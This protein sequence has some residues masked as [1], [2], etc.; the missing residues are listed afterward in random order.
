MFNNFFKNL[1]KSDKSNYYVPPGTNPTNPNQFKQPKGIQTQGYQ[2]GALY[3]PPGANFKPFQIKTG[4]TF[5]KISQQA[6]MSVQEIQQAN[7]GMLVPPPKGSY[8]NLPYKT[9]TPTVPGMNPQLLANQ[10]R[11]AGANSFTSGSNVNL[12]ELQSNI[13]KQLSSGTLPAQIPYQVT[14]TL[15]NPTTGKPFRD[16]DFK[17]EGYVYNNQK[18][19][20][21]LPSAN[22]IAQNQQ[23]QTAQP[24]TRAQQRAYNTSQGLMWDKHAG[25]WVPRE[26]WIRRR[27]AA[28]EKV[29]KK[30]AAPT[31]ATNS[32]GLPATTLDVQ[33][34]GGD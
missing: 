12:T 4:D 24:A 25:Q 29:V 15:L 16:A 2:G 27:R 30:T 5:D 17:A 3:V 28:P 9:F 7:G 10:S 26:E 20:W 31:L 13:T 14:K 21:E 22:T 32:G 19:T 23:Q 33:I 6:N 18:Q 8:I 34:G 11:G 1:F